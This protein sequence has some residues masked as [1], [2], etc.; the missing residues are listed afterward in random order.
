MLPY[1]KT[2]YTNFSPFLKYLP[3]LKRLLP[4]FSILLGALFIF[5]FMFSCGGLTFL[6]CVFPQKWFSSHLDTWGQQVDTRHFAIFQEAKKT[7]PFFN[8]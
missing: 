7:V 2:Q 3:T 1:T 6:P 4:Y 5:A 8:I